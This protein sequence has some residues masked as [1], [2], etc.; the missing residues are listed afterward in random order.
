MEMELAAI[1]FGSKPVDGIQSPDRGL[2][3][4]FQFFIISVP[5]DKVK[6]WKTGNGK[7]NRRPHC[8][9]AA[10]IPVY[11]EPRSFSFRRLRF[12]NSPGDIPADFWN[13]CAK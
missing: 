5:S 9:T 11:Q 6:Q 8:E 2:L 7:K 3:Y 4:P 1:T 13:T 12:R 10:S